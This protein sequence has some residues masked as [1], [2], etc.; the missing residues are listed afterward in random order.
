M[1]EKKEKKKKRTGKVS[2]RENKRRNVW[3]SKHCKIEIILIC[4]VMRVF[5]VQ[6]RSRRHLRVVFGVYRDTHLIERKHIA[7]EGNCS[8]IDRR[9]CKNCN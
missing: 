6:G 2:L 8:S 5:H 1:A 7:S 9:N 3:Y 4:F